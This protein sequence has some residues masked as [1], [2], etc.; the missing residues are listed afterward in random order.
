[1]ENHNLKP[2]YHIEI[3]R[4]D[5]LLTV[6]EVSPILQI[7]A[8]SIYKILSGERSFPLPTAIKLGRFWRFKESEVE[9]FIAELGVVQV[10]A[11]T[12]VYLEEKPKRGRPRLE[13]REMMG[14]TA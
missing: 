12:P 9:R 1:M 5:R 8:S 7:P 13:T 14:V 2:K 3:R 4:I 11:E 6:E 10:G